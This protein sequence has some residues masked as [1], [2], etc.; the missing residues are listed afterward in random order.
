VTAEFLVKFAVQAMP[1]YIHLVFVPLFKKVKV[2]TFDITPI[3]SETP[4][5]KRSGVARLLNGSHS[6]TCTPTCSFSQSE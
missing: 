6:F 2:H 1:S 3:R 5:Q 4:L